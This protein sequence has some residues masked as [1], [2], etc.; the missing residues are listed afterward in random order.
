MKPVQVG[1]LA[2][3]IRGTAICA[4]GERAVCYEVYQLGGRP[5]YGFI[6]E[7]GRYDGFSEEDVEMILEISDT[8]CPEIADYQFTNVMQLSSDFR[9]GRFAAAFPPL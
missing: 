8:V 4:A 1:T 2:T 3:A 6:F 9:Q 7:R 5:G